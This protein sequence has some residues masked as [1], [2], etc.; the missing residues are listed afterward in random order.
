MNDRPDKHHRKE[1]L[2]LIRERQRAEARAA[3]PLA[4]GELRAM[5]DELDREL[6]IHGCDRTRRLTLSFLERRG[7][8]AEAVLP[9][10]DDNGCFCDCEILANVEER[11]FDCREDKSR[12]PNDQRKSRRQFKFP[13]R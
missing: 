9:W 10:L 8:R 7:L 13:G 2:R 1:T 12:R 5:F 4:D 6:P 3:L 11:W